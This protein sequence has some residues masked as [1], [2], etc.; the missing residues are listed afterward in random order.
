MNEKGVPLRSAGSI[1]PETTVAANSGGALRPVAIANAGVFAA[2][3]VVIVSVGA[4]L[5]HLGA[6]EL[7]SVV[8]FAIVG[9]RYRVRAVAAAAVAA[10][11][12]AFLVAGPPATIVVTGCA[13]LGGLCGIIRRHGRG[14]GT[15]ALVASVLAPVSAVLVVGALYIFSAARDLTIGSLRASLVGLGRLA[16][17]IPGAA[18]IV[19]DAETVCDT[20][21]RAWPLAVSAIVILAVPAGILATN[22]VVV[23]IARRVEW[24]A[25]S[26]P[27]EHVAYADAAVGE[28]IAPVPL[29]LVGAGLRYG[30]PW[31]D[32]RDMDTGFHAA[33][34]M[35][36]AGPSGR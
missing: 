29:E 7:L 31:G 34:D 26:D 35:S 8:P 6:I 18:P 12:T 32:P 33:M 1:S 36:V 24:L 3:A 20:L 19:H 21:L 11:F 4:F 25:H 14:F 15:I 5:P 17:H 27:L 28:A 13:V 30:G 2:L 10:A 22:T 23:L 9:L 16:D